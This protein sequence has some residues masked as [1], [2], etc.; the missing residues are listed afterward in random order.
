MFQTSR[1]NTFGMYLSTPFLHMGSA[2]APVK[3]KSL[4][5]LVRTNAVP[6]TLGWRYDVSLMDPDRPLLPFIEHVLPEGTEFVR[7]AESIYS[8]DTDWGPTKP[9]VELEEILTPQQ[10]L[11]LAIENFEHFRDEYREIAPLIDKLKKSLFHGSH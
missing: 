1:D 9:P 3:D 2:I 4:Q 11:Q 8:G 10:A 7:I 6:T 5:L